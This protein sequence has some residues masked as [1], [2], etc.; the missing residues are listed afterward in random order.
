VQ[1]LGERDR[2]GPGAN[3]IQPVFSKFLPE[4]MRLGPA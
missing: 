3:G 2:H 4:S 1:A